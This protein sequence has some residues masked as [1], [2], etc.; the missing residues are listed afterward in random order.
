MER[1]IIFKFLKLQLIGLILFFVFDGFDQVI[2]QASKVELAR[3]NI[4]SNSIYFAIS[5]AILGMITIVAL[6]QIYHMTMI[7]NH[8]AVV[9]NA[10]TDSHQ[11]DIEF[12]VCGR[13]EDRP[14]I[15][16][17]PQHKARE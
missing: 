3:D 16:R 2:E 17:Q 4:A 14:C 1:R 9:V 15:L 6:P 12:H 5:Q 11:L 13:H 10:G 8:D 7:E